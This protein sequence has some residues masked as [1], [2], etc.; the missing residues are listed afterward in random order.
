MKHTNNIANYPE[1]INTKKLLNLISIHIS[2]NIKYKY[3]IYTVTISK[4]YDYI[5]VKLDPNC[6]VFPD[7]H[8]K[9]TANKLP[10]LEHILNVHMN[11]LLIS[12]QNNVSICKQHSFVI[13]TYVYMNL[14]VR[15]YRNWSKIK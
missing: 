8:H 13:G 15:K 2:N 10:V 14:G 1:Y 12:N 5:T 4:Y 7:I 11:D 9:K 3:L 6:L